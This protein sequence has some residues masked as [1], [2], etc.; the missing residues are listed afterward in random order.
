MQNS[1][2]F[3]NNREKDKGTGGN[4]YLSTSQMTQL[5]FLESANWSRYYSCHSLSLSLYFGITPES[6]GNPFGL[7]VLIISKHVIWTYFRC[8]ASCKIFWLYWNHTD[9]IRM[10]EGQTENNEMG[11]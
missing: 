1:L 3:V 10:F 11:A 4:I 8:L 5:F 7:S 2:I 9:K 6:L